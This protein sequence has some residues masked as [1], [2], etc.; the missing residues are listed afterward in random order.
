MG[1]T[2]DTLTRALNKRRREWWVSPALSQKLE[3]SAQILEKNALVEAIYD[4]NL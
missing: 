2:K 3:K 1:T 4:L